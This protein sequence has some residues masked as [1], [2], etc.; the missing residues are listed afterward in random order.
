[1]KKSEL[2]KII[3]EELQKVLKENHE[4]DFIADQLVNAW[5]ENSPNEMFQHLSG[6]VKGVDKN[7]L[8]KLVDDWY[9]DSRRRN[10]VLLLKKDVMDWIQEYI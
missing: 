10:D 1:M 5:E 6:Q 8:K 9:K 7:K 3:K 2:R 4:E